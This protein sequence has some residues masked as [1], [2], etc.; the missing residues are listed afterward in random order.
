[1]VLE[2]VTVASYGPPAAIGLRRSIHLPVASAVPGTS[3]SPANN[4]PAS[5]AS[6]G[7]YATPAQ[8]IDSYTFPNATIGITGGNQPHENTAPT[9]TLNYCIATVGVWPSQN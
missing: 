2:P 5:V 3:A 6:E 7:F 8:G 9:L 4:L 1:M